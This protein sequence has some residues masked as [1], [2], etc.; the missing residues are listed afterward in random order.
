MTIETP[1]ARPANACFSS[2][3]CAK[4]PG[5]TPEILKDAALGSWLPFAA[6]FVASYLTGAFSPM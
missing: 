2:G 5:W 3:P 4:R 6:I 1:A